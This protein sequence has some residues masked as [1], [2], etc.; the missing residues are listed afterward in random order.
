[1]AVIMENCPAKK[2]VAGKVSEG[3]VGERRGWGQGGWEEWGKSWMWGG[4][5]T[6]GK[7]IQGMGRK[8]GQDWGQMR[9][10]PYLHAS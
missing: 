6:M 4:E 9:N 3:E 8:W 10:L 1:M 5:G 2:V 7:G